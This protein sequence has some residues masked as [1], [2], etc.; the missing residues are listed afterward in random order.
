MSEE[1]MITASLEGARILID[2]ERCELQEYDFAAW[3]L[4]GALHHRTD[5]NADRC[6]ARGFAKRL[7]WRVRRH[8]ASRKGRGRRGERRG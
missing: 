7:R 3:R 6:R 5:G 2:K 1:K 8:P 4:L